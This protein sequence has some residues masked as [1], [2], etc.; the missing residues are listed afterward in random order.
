MD[1]WTGNEMFFLLNFY[2]IKIALNPENICISVCFIIRY[3]INNFTN[4]HPSIAVVHI[5]I[6]LL[7]YLLK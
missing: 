6:F 3:A 2:A 5:S 1:K 4:L 7:T